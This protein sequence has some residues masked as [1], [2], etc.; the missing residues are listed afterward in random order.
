MGLN[1]K[2]G[3]AGLG[4]GMQ[5]FGKMYGEHL[6]NEERR[7]LEREKMEQSKE[8]EEQRFK[9]QRE[10]AKIRNEQL[11]TQTMINRMKYDN[12]VMSKAA[13]TARFDPEKLVPT[14]NNNSNTGY[15]FRFNAAES[16]KITASNPDGKKGFAYDVGVWKTDPE[17]NPLLD[18]NGKKIFMELPGDS[19]LQ[20]WKNIDDY[21]NWYSDLANPSMMWAR[22]QNEKNADQLLEQ[23]RKQQEMKDQSASGQAAIG[24]KGAQQA[25]AQ[26]R[27]DKLTAEKGADNKNYVSSFKGAT[28]EEVQQTSQDVEKAKQFAGSL[29][30]SGKFEKTLDADDAARMMH[31]KNSDGAQKV[32]SGYLDKA[33]KGKMTEAEFKE[34][35]KDSKLPSEFIQEMWTEGMKDYVPEEEKKEGGFWDRFFGVFGL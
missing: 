22:Y 15:A 10:D 8:L 5:I 6:E 26:A 33:K 7:T 11:K 3:L 27:A 34:K 23:A 20:T 2:G 30:K 19:K 9:A 32:I 24:L 28:G 29:N 14:L 25:E 1:W 4:Q 31:I 21:T 17:G 13:I 18:E 35:F 12:E 16:D